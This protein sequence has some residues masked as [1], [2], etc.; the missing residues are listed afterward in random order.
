MTRIRT[1]LAT[2]VVAL[3][4]VAS[5]VPLSADTATAA[6]HSFVVEQGDR[7]FEVSPLRGDQNVE[8]F[9]DYRHPNN[10]DSY[11]YSSHMPDHL[12]RE[13]ASRLFLYEGP[14]GVSLV[15]LHNERDGTGGGHAVSFD[16]QGLPSDGEWAVVDD[17]YGGQ[18]DRFSRNSIDW[19]L[20]SD[21]TDGGAFRG[22]DRSDTAITVTPRFNENAA[23]YDDY[24]RSDRIESWQVL[25]GDLGSPDVTSLTMGQAITI[26]TG[27]CTDETP[28]DAALSA[29]GGVAGSPTTLDARNAT[30][31]ETGIAEYRWDFD[32]DGS[33]DRTTDGAQTDYTYDEAGEYRPRVTVVD[34]GGNN[35]TAAASLTVEADD[36]PTPALEV[37]TDEPAEGTVVG[38]DASNSTDDTG[39]AAYRWNFGDGENA[40]GETVTHTYDGNGTYTVTLE[41]ADEGGNEA[42]EQVDL[43]VR[44]SDDTPPEVAASATLAEVEAGANVTFDAGDS[45]DG[46]TGIARYEWEFGDGATATGENVTHAYG[47]AGTYD[48]TVTVTDESGNANSTDVTV[49]VLGAGDP[50]ASLSV[51]DDETEVGAGVTFDASNSSDEGTGIAEYRWDFDGNG[52]DEATESPTVTHEYAEV[53][54]VTA[55]VTVVD[56]AGNADSATVA[57]VV[58]PSEKAIDDGDSGGSDGGDSGGSAGGS[59]G[60]SS[61]GG[62]A[63]TG[64]P[65]IVTDVEQLG[66]NEAA[67]DV[68]NGRTGETIRGELPQSEAAAETGVRFTEVGVSLAAD[69]PH[70]VIETA[71]AAEGA[72][73]VPADATLGSLAV[74]TKY[75]DAETVENATYE[76][77]VERTRLDEAG[78]AP[79]DLAVYQRADG[80][81]TQVDAT[82]EERDDRIVLRARTDALGDL[83]VGADRSLTVSDAALADEEVAAS[84]PVE[85][86]AT[87]RNEGTDRAEFDVEL[88][89]DGDVVAT[90]TVEIAGGET[91]EVAFERKLEPGA[92]EVSV[93][94]ESVGSVTVAEPAANIA[95]ADVS[96]NAST[97]APGDRVE[98]TATVEN[99]GAKAGEHEV[100]LTLFG[101]QLENRTVELAAGETKE[102]TFV[103]QIS[104]AGIY[105]AEVGDQAAEITVGDSQT[106]DDESAV[107]SA[108]VPGFGVG[109]AVVALLAAAFLART[110]R[111][112]E[113]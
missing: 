78:F 54:N 84:D 76:V 4:L 14:D 55:T 28:P 93:E 16:F 104:A 109:T 110:R 3:L 41:V 107:P 10:S 92:H 65:P 48:A 102:V 101:E 30:D 85:V 86:T 51:S 97:I 35:D 80:G 22:L 17:N 83:A 43:S 90:K 7:C 58:E 112:D 88:V 34:G 69:D 23:L 37:S 9:Y 45:T 73:E 106:S 33:T 56:R 18:D 98:I 40:T 81:W 29:D 79:D 44:P 26:R 103:R 105:T 53:G 19:T 77:A 99:S 12:P 39:V 75:L 47:A 113:P 60:S 31:G 8:S 15:M 59:S 108:P 64:P 21:R 94:G 5:A 2:V 68:Q 72:D 82:V 20:R 25:S 57:M 49:E 11:T 63:S 36:P 95:V 67:V 71:R 27:S 89:A 66:P 62:A 6:Q 38:F 50:T 87:V 46:E 32:G 13:D 74:G 91:A 1:Q 70:F 52:T 96:L 61:G 24:N 100:A 42:T 111:S